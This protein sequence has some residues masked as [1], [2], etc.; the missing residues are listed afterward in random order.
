MEAGAAEEN[1]PSA[2]DLTLLRAYRLGIIEGTIPSQ[3]EVFEFSRLS[4][5]MREEWLMN[6]SPE[7]QQALRAGIDKQTTEVLQRLERGPRAQ[8]AVSAPR[9]CCPK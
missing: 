8:Q 1:P 7:K 2:K 5:E 4:E 3:R 6:F 9:S